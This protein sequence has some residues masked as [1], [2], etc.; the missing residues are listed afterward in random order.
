MVV[1]KMTCTKAE[2][3]QIELSPVTS[4]SK[5]NEQFYKYTPGGAV[6]LSTVNEAAAAYFEPGKEYYVRFEAA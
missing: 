2:D 4:G 6:S 5:E 3:G 1:A